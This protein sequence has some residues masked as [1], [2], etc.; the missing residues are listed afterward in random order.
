MTNWIIRHAQIFDG[1]GNPPYIADIAIQGDKII[2]IGDYSEH[3]ADCEIDAKGKALLPGFI[4]AHT[5]SDAV[6]ANGDKREVA[7]RQ[8]IT[9]EV[10]GTCGIGTVPLSGKNRSYL[11]FTRSIIGNLNE[12]VDTESVEAFLKSRSCY[13]TN[14]GLQVAHSP[15]RM[16]AIGNRDIVPTEQH[17]R[18]METLLEEAFEQGACAFTT[19]L[20][21]YPASFCDTSEL[22]RLCKVAKQYERPFCIHQRSVKSR[23][24]QED[25]DPLQEAI[26]I[27]E[28]SGVRLHLSHY[29][30]RLYSVGEVEQLLE[31]IERAKTKGIEITA[32]FYPYGVGCGDV[33]VNLPLWVMDGSIEDV[34][35]RL[36]DSKTKV[37]IA[38]EM[39][40]SRPNLADGIFTHAPLHPEYVGLSYAQVAEKNG[41][42]VS[43]MLVR[44]LYEAR[45]EG[46]YMPHDSK[47][48]SVQEQLN[49]DYMKLLEK[50][51]YMVG[52]DT[53]PAHMNPHPRSSQTFTKILRL[54]MEQNVPLELIA[55]RLCDNPAKLFG[56]KERGRI[57]VGNKADI[58]LLGENGQPEWVWIN[59]ICCLKQGEFMSQFAGCA[60]YSDKT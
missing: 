59:G 60:L 19:G 9:T 20:S 57:D 58:V 29:K 31:P 21:Y 51:Y 28:E 46:G 34:L 11:Q 35:E 48:L 47:D 12:D 1:S 15:L 8:G 22:I 13:G 2:R 50:P 26:K 6:L 30:T 10:V 55:N 41:E 16:E 24:M 44:Y 7:I 27:A 49:K 23:R 25:I 3:N 36:S 40:K 45:L 42:T 53:L 43:Q 38:K 37:R 14:I 18:R 54:A 4:D 33:A 52:S 56:F 32:D 17:M 5:H 39:E